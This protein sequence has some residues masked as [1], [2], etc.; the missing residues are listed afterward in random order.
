PP[1][2]DHVDRFNPE[3]HS[4]VVPADG[5]LAGESCLV[6]FPSALVKGL[7]R[8]KRSTTDEDR[9]SRGGPLTKRYVLRI[10]PP[11]EM[12]EMLADAGRT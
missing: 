9:S 10:P 4:E 11:K 3:V 6:I 2:H 7:P 12:E 8:S 1:F 5:L